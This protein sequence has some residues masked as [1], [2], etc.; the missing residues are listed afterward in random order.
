MICLILLPIVKLHRRINLLIY[1]FDFIYKIILLSR[2]RR[3]II[4]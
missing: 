1:I 2:F 4:E 3:Y